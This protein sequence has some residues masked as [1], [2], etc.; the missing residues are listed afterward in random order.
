MFTC[1]TFTFLMDH[2]CYLKIC[3]TSDHSDGFVSLLL[4]KKRIFV[5]EML[6]LISLIHLVSLLDGKGVMAIFL[7]LFFLKRS[8]ELSLVFLTEYKSWTPV[9]STRILIWWLP[10]NTMIVKV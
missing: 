3:D 7:M 2:H 1:N 10:V 5:I 9:I 6:S 4:T 8:S